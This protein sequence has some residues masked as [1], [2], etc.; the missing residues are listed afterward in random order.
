MQ[1]KCPGQCL[2]HCKGALLLFLRIP[3]VPW[4]VRE[5]WGDTWA[6]RAGEEV[7]VLE[8]QMRMREQG[9]D[10]CVVSLE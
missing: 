1:G 3:S 8:P 10:M 2:A 9:E 5:P 6:S 7:L 4:E